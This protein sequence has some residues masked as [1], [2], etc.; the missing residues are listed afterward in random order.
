MATAKEPLVKIAAAVVIIATD[1]ALKA[2][3]SLPCLI[4]S[5]MRKPLKP[6]KNIPISVPS[7]QRAGVRAKDR[8]SV[9]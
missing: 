9:V 8:K 1:D 4:S 6:P 5:R 7:P 3:F 2:G